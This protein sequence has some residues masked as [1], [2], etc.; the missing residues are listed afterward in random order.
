[1][2]QRFELR[3]QQLLAE[4]DL[5]P[6]T[7]DGIIERL[8]DFVEPFAACLVRDEQRRHAH[9][10]LAGLVSDLKRKNTEAIAYRHA[11]DRN[12]PTHS[13]GP[14]PWDHQPLL[15]ELARQVGTDLG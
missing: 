3:K 6:E 1:M 13:V 5:R 11:L 8:A 10:H 2:Q 15:V 14:P 12:G 4:C 9:T 7:F